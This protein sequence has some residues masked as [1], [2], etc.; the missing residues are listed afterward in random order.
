MNWNYHPRTT[1][2]ISAHELQAQILSTDIS[3]NTAGY[4]T[5]T[6]PAP[7]GGSSSASWA[8]VEVHDP[9]STIVMNS[10]T[11]YF[12]GFWQLLVAD[13][14]HDAILDLVDGY[15]L[16]LGTGKGSFTI[17]SGVDRHYLSPWQ[18]AYGCLLYT[19]PRSFPMSRSTPMEL[20]TRSK[21]C[22][23]WPRW[24]GMGRSLM[25]TAMSEASTLP[26]R[27]VLIPFKMS[28]LAMVRR[29]S[30]TQAA[31]RRLPRQQAL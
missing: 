8:Q 27:T 17:S 24:N 1:T 30:T 11:Y 29:L 19:S 25:S 4:I 26:G 18:I 16:D 3:N 15:D 23:A 14:N 7:G 13:F 6:N 20:S 28:T 2:Y 12:F 31:T 9:V 10:P 21:T 5:V 22:R